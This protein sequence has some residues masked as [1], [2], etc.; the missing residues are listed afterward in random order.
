MAAVAVGGLHDHISPWVRYWG[1]RISG[2]IGIPDIAGK[3]NSFCHFIF[4]YSDFN[5]RGT[6]KDV[7][8]LQNA[9][10]YREKWRIYL[11]SCRV[12]TDPGS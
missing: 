8:H 6:P 4:G 12:Q 3:D 2:L 11:H 1:L 5:G 10:V 7:R 9:P